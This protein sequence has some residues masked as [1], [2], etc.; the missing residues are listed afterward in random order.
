MN[1]KTNDVSQTLLMRAVEYAPD[2]I[3]IIDIDGYIIYFNKAMQRIYGLSPQEYKGKH[4]RSM[5]ILSLQKRLYLL[6]KKRGH[7][8]EN[9]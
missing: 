7:G 3:Q 1:E 4:V 2:G 5:L 6:L 9:L 8:Q